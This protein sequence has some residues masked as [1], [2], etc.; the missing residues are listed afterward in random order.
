MSS[1]FIPVIPLHTSYG[2]QAKT[3]VLAPLPSKQIRI[4]QLKLINRSGNLCDTGILI[5]LAPNQ[6]KQFYYDGAIAHDISSSVQNNTAAQIFDTTAG[7]AIVVQAKKKFNM[8]GIVVSTAATGSPSFTPKYF[9]GSSFVD[10]PDVMNVPIFGS[11]G[12]ALL[13]FSSP[14]DWVQ[15]GGLTGIDSLLYTI[16]ILGASVGNQP[17]ATSIKVA[18]MVDFSP[19][20]NINSGMENDWS[21]DY[22]LHLEANEGLIPYFSVASPLNLVTAFYSQDN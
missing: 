12:Y 4:F 9:N 10:I 21:I 15:G 8:I 6:T 3:I 22:P 2:D 19:G 1:H 16:K 18:S 13:V 7:T 14:I 20:V 17:Q 5:S 11:I